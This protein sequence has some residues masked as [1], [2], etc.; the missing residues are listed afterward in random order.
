VPATDRTHSPVRVD[1][2]HH[3]VLVGLMGAGKTAVGRIV[4]DRLGCPFIDSDEIVKER[5]GMTVAQ[6]WR[7]GGEAAY[8]PHEREAVTQTLAAEGPDV[9]A[10]PAGAIVDDVALASL[11]R[12]GVFIVW[13]RAE[14]DTL[15]RRAEHGEHRPLLDE[16][17]RAVLAEQAAE[18]SDAY[19][20]LADL[21]LDVEDR[22]AEELADEILAAL[23]PAAHE[24][25]GS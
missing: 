23:P 7:R 20:A 10:G 22:S 6:L 1:D 19:E 11:H 14:V 21:V 9:L 8:R 18:R 2:V 24:A 15:A 16:D 3:I 5:T 12:P 13:L 25:E 17:P 4:A